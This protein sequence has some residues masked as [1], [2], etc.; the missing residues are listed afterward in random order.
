M[1]GRGE[2]SHWVCWCRALLAQKRR[3][4]RPWVNWHAGQATYQVA[5]AEQPTTVPLPFCCP[6]ECRSIN[7][8]G[9]FAV[10][11]GADRCSSPAY[12]TI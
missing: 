12:E 1:V 6:T 7:F 9:V 2:G 10:T 11:R 3:A 5:L 8:C 4:A